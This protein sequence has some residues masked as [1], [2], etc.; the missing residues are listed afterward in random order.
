[1]EKDYH[2]ML[3]QPLCDNLDALPQELKGL[4]APAK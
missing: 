1:M 4:V 2:P 3:S